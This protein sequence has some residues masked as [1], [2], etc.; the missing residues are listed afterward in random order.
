MIS[1]IV[2][3]EISDHLKSLRFVLTF[4]L[5]VILMAVS[6]FLFVNEYKQQTDDFSRNRNESLAQMSERASNNGGLFMVY[7]F[8]FN[9]P[10]IYKA[11][12]HLS[13][14]SEG[15]D[16]NLPNAFQPSA[17]KVFGPAKRIR[18]N[19]LLWRSDPIDWVM[20]IGII[21]SFAALLLV[22]DSVSG[23]RENGTLRL[24][25]SNSVSRS[26]LLFG[27]FL[28]GL[29]PI[30]AAL[31]AGVL[32]HL[33]IL[34]VFGTIPIMAADWGIVGLTYVLSVIYISI[35][36]MLGIFISAQTRESVTSIVVALIC[37]A[38]LVIVIPRTGGLFAS[39]VIDV[40]SWSDESARASRMQNEARSAYEENNPELKGTGISGHW[41]PGEPLERA[42]VM[43]DAWSGVV[44]TYQNQLINQVE[45][46]RKLIL[47]SP[48][49][50][51][52]NCIEKL[53]G[54]GIE[55]YKTF[56]NNVRDYKLVMRQ[57]LLDQYTLPAN[58]HSGNEKL[59]TPENRAKFDE[60]LKPLDPDTVPQF[61]SKRADM[62][63]MINEA[64]LYIFLLILFNILFFAGAFVSFLRYDVR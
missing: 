42:I 37:W 64:L 14:I 21:L 30:A 44:D 25:L 9:G 53:T 56:F 45:L 10:W 51:F 13:F 7:S 22:Y 35:F 18:S 32:I 19:I 5:I 4:A 59:R 55:H 2:F 62:V 23:E 8:N 38:L 36:L 31:L 39:R 1:T 34:S 12:N 26:T 47:V 15:H 46:A 17:F 54:S 60:V 16:S 58:W 52:T 41:S 49:V 33:I 29:I 6:A 11:P 57:S 63:I 20:I 28:G 48:F 24:F 27:K 3:K 61:Q 50:G 43:S 40:P